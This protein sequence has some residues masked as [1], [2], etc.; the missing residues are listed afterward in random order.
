V[1]VTFNGTTVEHAFS[2]GATIAQVK[3]WAAEKKFGIAE[4]DAGELVLQLAGKDEQPPANTHI[5]SLVPDDGRELCLNLV[6]K[7]RING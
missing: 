3:N 5:G 2:P 4:E 7:R 1:K 6:P